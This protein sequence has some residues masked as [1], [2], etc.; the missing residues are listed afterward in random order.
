V[1]FGNSPFVGGGPQFA[2]L[3][4]DEWIDFRRESPFFCGFVIGRFQQAE[5]CGNAVAL[6]APL[7][8]E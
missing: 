4:F 8:K 3:E 7:N 6:V 5:F 1:L 2:Y